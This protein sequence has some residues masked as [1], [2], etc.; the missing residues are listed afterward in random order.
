[1]GRTTRPCDRALA[2][3]DS[4]TLLREIRAPHAARVPGSRPANGLASRNAW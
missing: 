1:M 3:P 2:A 4:A